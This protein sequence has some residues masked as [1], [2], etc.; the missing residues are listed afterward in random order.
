MGINPGT[1]ADCAD[2]LYS[3]L[4]VYRHFQFVSSGGTDVNGVEDYLDD[5]EEEE[6]E[7]GDGDGEE[8]EDDEDDDDEDG[9]G[10]I[11]V[12]AVLVILAVVASPLL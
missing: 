11:S 3:Y 2:E 9:A 5:G 4:D 7:Y 1:S 12:G 6:E 8:E 10:S